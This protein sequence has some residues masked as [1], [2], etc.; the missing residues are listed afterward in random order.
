M[1]SVLM[2]LALSVAATGHPVPECTDTDG[3]CQ[4]LL[5]LNGA[6]TKVKASVMELL[7]TQTRPQD[8][9][10]H[11]PDC[12]EE[13]LLR[14][15]IS[16]SFHV[17]PLQEC[18]D[19]AGEE[20]AQ[21]CMTNQGH[22]V[23]LP[24]RLIRMTF[25][26]A[27]DL[28]NLLYMN[29]THAP[30]HEGGVDSCL[31]TALLSTGRSQPQGDET[32]AGTNP[33]E[34][35]DEAVGDPNHN[36]GLGNAV[37]WINKLHKEL[38]LS[39]PDT[40]ILGAVVAMEAW[41]GF[42]KP[43]G[44]EFG[45][46]RGSCNVPIC[47]RERCWDTETLFFVQAIA[48]PVGSGMMC[49]ATNTNQNTASLLGISTEEL[50][51]L[52]GAHSVGGII[53]CSGLGNVAAGAYCPNK[54]GS[55][56]F[57][58][59]NLDGSTFDDT[60]G[61][62][63]NRYYQLLADE[64]YEELPH[65]GAV[66]G[67]PQLS[68]R[69]LF[70]AGDDSSTMGGSGELK[71]WQTKDLTE[72]C[73][74][75][76]S[77]PRESACGVEKCLKVCMD[78]EACEAAAEQ[79]PP[80]PPDESHALFKEK[81]AYSGSGSGG[82]SGSNWTYHDF[83]TPEHKEC[84]ECKVQCSAGYA[85]ILAEK[86][87]LPCVRECRTAMKPCLDSLDGLQAQADQKRKNCTE[88]RTSCPDSLV[89]NGLG[90]QLK[91]SEM[92]GAVKAKWEVCRNMFRGVGACVKT[93]T[94][95]RKEKL[96]KCRDPAIK[97]R[98]DARKMN[99]AMR[100]GFTHCATQRQTCSAEFTNLIGGLRQGR[101]TCKG[102]L[103]SCVMTCTDKLENARTADGKAHF[104][105]AD[106]Q[107]ESS[108]NASEIQ[109]LLE[110]GIERSHLTDTVEE[111]QLETYELPANWERMASPEEEYD[112]ETDA[113]IK[114]SL[115]A[116]DDDISAMALIEVDDAPKKPARWCLRTQPHRECLDGK[117]IISNG[118]WGK[119]PIHLQ[120]E[121]PN[122]GTGRITTILNLERTS[123]YRGLSK[124]VV[125]LP[126]DWSY[127][128]DPVL[129]Q[130][131]KN[132]A[133]DEELWKTKFSSAWSK[134]SSAGW[135]LEGKGRVLEQCKPV[136]CQLDADEITCD[137]GSDIELVFTVASCDTAP[138]ADAMACSLVGAVGLRAQF[139]CEGDSSEQQP[140][141]WAG[142]CCHSDACD[143]EQKIKEHWETT[144]GQSTLC[145]SE[146]K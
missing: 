96:S 100:E 132:F 124:R 105:R 119:C 141:K 33:E 2:L 116:M 114:R 142:S 61:L 69:G 64:D 31:H 16:Q 98:D 4:S 101:D 22:A 60:P 36:R 26:D 139:S 6:S 90:E 46:S 71:E 77:F 106:I 8:E 125:V 20:G 118:G 24:P 120:R 72:V 55:P 5:Q 136:E 50:I 70:G 86:E 129:K 82:G 25:H 12:A 95:S 41:L 58:N 3:T 84:V 87:H 130:H 108:L 80:K 92:R 19:R 21:R 53:V 34:E 145:E 73:A 57:E 62:L 76:L 121:T 42:N 56:V 27:A 59:R 10:P 9:A 38:D 89:S 45:R 32:E 48:E 37:R 40:Q 52:Q 18:L 126:S 81:G 7:D 14:F 134:L 65:C 47:T 91:L 99:T 127:L 122:L 74:A 115:A 15:K 102:T 30:A 11:V 144:G 83:V 78:T 28:G 68:K 103:D 117:P 131:F 49:P 143:E 140:V 23:A 146:S 93:S 109:S 13:I 43:L 17:A 107:S 39:E 111:E 44:M 112:F 85:Q 135:T 29:G 63:D 54:C 97:C 1:R 51:A 133:T 79:A 128:G 110:L 75:G 94:G 66:R 123:K 88:L 137:G 138:P 104:T 67:W 35:E 113:G